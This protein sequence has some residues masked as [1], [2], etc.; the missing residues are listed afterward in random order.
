MKRLS[1]IDVY[2][3]LHQ[4]ERSMWMYMLGVWVVSELDLRFQYHIFVQHFADPL[5]WKIIYHSLKV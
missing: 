3:T 4:L 5:T 2:F 1:N